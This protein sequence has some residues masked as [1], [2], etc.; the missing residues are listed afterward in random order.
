MSSTI[1]EN[2]ILKGFNPDPS[3]IKVN[4]DYYIAT[5]TFEWFPGVQIFHSTDLINWTLVARP[6]NRTSQLDMLGNPD[7]CG[8]WAPCLSYNN[9]TFYLIYSNARRYWS[10]CKDV[11]NYLVTTNDILGEWSEPV[12]LNSSGFDP[13][14]FHDKNGKKWLVNLRWDHRQGQSGRAFNAK[15]YFGGIVLQQYSPEQEKLVGDVKKIFAGSSLGLAE[16]PHLYQRNGY[17]Y[18]LVAEGG[19][20]Y[21]H[22]ALMLR[23]K[24]I[25]GPYEAD[26]KGHFLTAA[27][28]TGTLQRTGHADFVDIDEN[29][30][31]LVHLCSRPL[32]NHRSVMG[33][34]TAIQK[35]QW[36]ADGWLRLS[37][38][39]SVPL[40]QP[41]TTL[42]NNS[43][44]TPTK[45]FEDFTSQQLPIDFQTLRVPLQS[46]S[47]SLSERPRYLRLK[48]RESL[49]SSFV[50]ALVARRQQA[51]KYSAA[52]KVDFTPNS[53]QQMAG[54]VCYYNSSKYYYLHITHHETLGRILE[55]TGCTGDTSATYFTPEPIR[56]PANGQVFLNAEVDHEKLVFF[57]GTTEDYWQKIPITLDYSIL[58]DETGKGGEHA[59]FTGTFVGLCCQDLSGNRHHA[60]FDW[61]SY[62]EHE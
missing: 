16:G 14:L 46:D 41:M 2:P 34:E 20:G 11:H 31:W 21:E 52:T 9:G 27:N 55:I 48:G 25:D 54:L 43:N 26:P 39:G 1:F 24:N 49:G 61:F 22:A 10:Q 60:D 56:L 4:N 50:Q 38:Q 19:T 32:K 45:Q 33:R 17:Y 47:L 28:T 23:S 53:F 35:A 7:S 42:E 30:A 13:S 57:Y 58:A 3:I 12:Y 29:H 44:K 5:S 59:N 37:H 6:L 15:N 36:S 62:I 8:V 40:L 51:F 18:L